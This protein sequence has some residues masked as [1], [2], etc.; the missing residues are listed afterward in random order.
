MPGER[1]DIQLFLLLMNV[2]S[3]VSQERNL[4]T[5]VLF[6]DYVTL[7][8]TVGLSDCHKC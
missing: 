6:A 5:L 8:V 2:G 3:Y 7:L 1:T 4:G